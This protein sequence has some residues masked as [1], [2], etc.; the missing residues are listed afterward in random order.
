MPSWRMTCDSSIVS[1]LAWVIGR[2][3]F[4]VL[5]K[6]M[7]MSLGVKNLK[8]D[9]RTGFVAPFFLRVVH[10]YFRDFADDKQEDMY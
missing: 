8:G 6:C 3:C 7:L 9:G 5:A 1:K 2:R 4:T 10:L